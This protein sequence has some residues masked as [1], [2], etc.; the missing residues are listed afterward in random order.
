MKKTLTSKA[1]ELD[2]PVIATDKKE[3]LDKSRIRD[4]K[5]VDSEHWIDGEWITDKELVR[6]TRKRR[7][8]ITGTKSLVKSAYLPC[9]GKFPDQ[10]G[11]WAH[12]VDSKNMVNG[13]LK[14]AGEIIGILKRDTGGMIEDMATMLQL[15]PEDFTKY[16]V[17]DPII[18]AQIFPFYAKAFE[19]LTG[20]DMQTRLAKYSE[21]HFKP[22][23]QSI[24]Y[25]SANGAPVP[26]N[27]KTG[28]LATVPKSIWKPP[29]GF[30]QV[31]FAKNQ[32]S[33][34]VS[35]PDYLRSIMP[36]NFCR[37]SCPETFEDFI[38]EYIA[39]R[40]QRGDEVDDSP[41]ARALFQVELEKHYLSQQ[42]GA[43]SVMVPTQGVDMF[44]D[45]CIGGRAD[46]RDVGIR[47]AMVY[48]DLKSAYASSLLMLMDHDF[49][50]SYITTGSDACEQ[51]MRDLLE[52]G[53]F[54]VVGIVLDWEFKPDAE[55]TFPL[56]IKGV[57]YN[58]QETVRLIFPTTGR[59]SVMWSEF[60]AAYTMGLLKKFTIYQIIEFKQLPT[61][62]LAVRIR[63]LL[64]MR[65][66]DD[67]GAVKAIINSF[68]GKTLQ[69]LSDVRDDLYDTSGMSSV[70]CF[71]LGAYMTGTTRSILGQAINLNHW[72]GTASDA[73][74]I[75]GHGPVN[76]GSL[77]QMI[78]E[79]M[80]PLG[81]TFVEIEF[82]ATSGLL[83][84]TKGYQLRGMKVKD[85]VPSGKQTMKIAAKGM[86]VDRKPDSLDPAVMGFQ[87]VDDFMTGLI[88]GKL[89][90]RNFRTFPD[91]K[92][93][94]D[95]NA[96]RRRELQ[97]KLHNSRNMQ[98]K[99]RDQAGI[100]STQLRAQYARL[101]P[102]Q[103]FAE[104]EQD[105]IAALIQSGT[106]RA[107]ALENVLANHQQL[108]QEYDEVVAYQIFPRE[109]YYTVKVNT[110]FDMKRVPIPETLKPA[111]VEFENA[112]L[113][114]TQRKKY[115][116]IH[117]SFETRPVYSEK[118]YQQLIK[119]AKHRMRYEDY[120][121]MMHELATAGVL[122]NYH[123]CS[124]FIKGD[125][126]ESSLRIAYAPTDEFIFRASEMEDDDI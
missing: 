85:G 105:R 52:L 81:F 9:R 112:S 5:N 79:E 72:H 70:T 37:E 24:H 32:D 18:A 94:Y 36:E 69:G 27:E 20:G 78:Q 90:Q 50:Q 19:H 16:A 111:T 66:G 30:R 4:R 17:G 15:Y 92:R 114:G 87:Q 10:P 62:H 12:F 80:N 3:W 6:R 76:A 108:Q 95:E 101:S 82:I 2:L 103:T 113:D 120:V 44:L 106:K 74:I 86:K 100:S 39:Y 34:T 48:A 83:V 7:R 54:L 58:G 99:L 14:K 53:P 63:E 65:K 31:W 93:Q 116:Y 28:K 55:P 124:A 51:R 23:F 33:I 102:N 42:P 40:R 84:T 46:C 118:E 97:Q 56:K 125:Y 64:V 67:H 109:Y 57:Q 21:A 119:A 26:I 104:Y 1:I 71:P 49:S 25:E 35:I 117:T 115:S 47:G 89:R 13:S 126:T 41:A 60:Y 11:V 121:A 29:M 123:D 98:S 68:F 43:Q 8:S 22:L 59:G 122:S 75:S 77:A 45:F 61:N 91:L 38:D 107:R 96:F 110:T 73:V 88:T